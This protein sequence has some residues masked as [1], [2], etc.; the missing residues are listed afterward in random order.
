M[1]GLWSDYGDR[2]VIMYTSWCRPVRTYSGPEYSSLASL[3]VSRFSSLR[4]R[5][6]PVASVF[7]GRNSAT[8][9]KFILC[10]SALL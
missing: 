9:L 10:L 5:L 3:S 7:R 6:C 2:S 4:L 8:Y 1:L